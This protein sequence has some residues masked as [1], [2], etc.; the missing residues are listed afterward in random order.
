MQGRSLPQTRRA[1]L[2]LVLYEHPAGWTAADLRGEIGGDARAAIADLL[3]D[4]LLE[5]DGEYVR[6]T[7][8]ALAF[9]RLELP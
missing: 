6:P 5:R 2:G 7:R 8:E 4:G 1:V 9:Y 3:A